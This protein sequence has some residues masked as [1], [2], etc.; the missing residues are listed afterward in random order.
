M[1]VLAINCGSSSIKFIVTNAS[2]GHMD[3]KPLARGHID[4]IGSPQSAIRLN[5]PQHSTLHE[6]LV[7]SDHSEGIRKTFNLLARYEELAPS[8]IDAVGHRFVHGGDVFTDPI[9]VDQ[10]VMST[11]GIVNLPKIQP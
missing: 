6:N 5:R 3:P 8:T 4:G 9:V 11:L 2:P 1:K 10:Q 7:V